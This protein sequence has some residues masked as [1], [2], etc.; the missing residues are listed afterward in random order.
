MPARRQTITCKNCGVRIT[1]TRRTRAPTRKTRRK[2]KRPKSAARVARGKFL[3]ANL[4]RDAKGKFLPRGSVNL[5]R[6]RKGKER[7]RE[8]STLGTTAKRSRTTSQ[9]EPEEG[10]SRFRFGG[11][12][13]FVPSLG[14]LTS[15]GVEAAARA[16]RA[17]I[18]QAARGALGLP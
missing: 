4:P 17:A 8:F 5:F 13:D 6:G 12:S 10:S 15:I 3:A 16:S 18:E 11:V 2:V 14:T 9:L 1:I 7:T